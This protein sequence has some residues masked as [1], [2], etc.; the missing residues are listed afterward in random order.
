MLLDLLYDFYFLF[1][2][3]ASFIFKVYVLLLYISL[4]IH[5]KSET[6]NPSLTCPSIPY[7]IGNLSTLIG[8]TY[9]YN[10]IQRA[11]SKTFTL[12]YFTNWMF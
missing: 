3:D 11:I 10:W 2:F 5:A 1:R 4:I 12:H 9:L 7:K 8:L 6:L